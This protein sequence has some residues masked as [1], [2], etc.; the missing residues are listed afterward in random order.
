MMMA[1]GC[2]AR[3]AAASTPRTRERGRVIAQDRRRDGVMRTSHDRTHADR[4]RGARPGRDAGRGPC[5]RCSSSR[6]EARRSSTRAAFTPSTP[7][8]RCKTRAMCTRDAVRPSTSGSYRRVRS[9]RRRPE[10]VGPFFD[11]GNDKPY[12][13]PQFYSAPRGVRV[14]DGRA[15]VAVHGRLLVTT[16]RRRAGRAHE[17]ALVQYLLRLGDDRLVLG[18]GFRSGAATRR[19]SKRISHS[20]TSHWI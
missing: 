19:S 11:P 8:A 1:R 3:R 10:D 13:H 18:H 2:A 20:P 9:R 17:D 5:G 15:A 14:F 12:R 16:R 4:G 6:P 7:R